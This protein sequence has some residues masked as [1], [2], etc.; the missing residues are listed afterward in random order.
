MSTRTVVA[1]AAIA[2][3][4][5]IAC[6]LALIAV[7]A[8][9]RIVLI[10][11]H[12]RTLIE[13]FG[14]RWTV[15]ESPAEFEP[16]CSQNGI[17]IESEEQVKNV[18]VIEVGWPVAAW[19]A[20]LKHPKEKVV[21]GVVTIRADFLYGETLYKAIPRL[22]PMGAGLAVQ[23]VLSATLVCGI[24]HSVRAAWRAW[25]RRR[26]ATGCCSNCG[27]DLAG[28]SG[29]VCPECGAAAAKTA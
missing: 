14:I 7:A 5:V 29:G 8:E 27:Y 26:P 4:L 6:D 9:S 15:L 20:I 19:Q 11:Q 28:A 18:S 23:W 12:N 3:L 22:R 16:L 13:P 25:R 1:A 21:P 10:P 17:P 24:T 2:L